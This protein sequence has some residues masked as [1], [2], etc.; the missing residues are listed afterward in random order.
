MEKDKWKRKYF[1]LLLV[2]VSAQ[3]EFLD[4]LI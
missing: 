1:L 4:Y 3:K 2:L